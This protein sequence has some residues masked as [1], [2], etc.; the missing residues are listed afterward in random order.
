MVLDGLVCGAALHCACLNGRVLAEMDVR[1]LVYDDRM[2]SHDFFL[3]LEQN[4]SVVGS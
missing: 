1:G 4:G 3:G 2:F